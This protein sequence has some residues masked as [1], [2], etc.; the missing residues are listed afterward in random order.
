[1]RQ[2]P[3]ETSDEQDG[4]PGAVTTSLL[5][6]ESLFKYGIES[7]AMEPALV[8]SA[9][10]FPANFEASTITNQTVVLGKTIQRK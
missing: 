3:T 6:C 2:T 4:S 9:N 7:T 10:R 8:R 1:M 5:L